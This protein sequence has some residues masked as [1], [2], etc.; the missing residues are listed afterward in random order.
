MF[1]AVEGCE[2][3]GKSCFVKALGNKLREEKQKVLL[4]REPG[5]SK[6][7]DSL[8]SL[9][10]DSHLKISPYAELF[11]FLAGRAHHIYDT[12]IPALQ[13]GFIVVSDRFHDSTI[14]YQGIAE[15]L[16]ADYVS[17][18]CNNVSGN[19]PFYPDLTILLDIPVEEGLARKRH[20]KVL[21][22]FEEKPIEY[23]QK[24]R[25]GF[26]SLANKQPNRYCILDARQSIEYSIN[27]LFSKKLTSFLCEK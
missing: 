2:G 13:E 6:L 10:L 9:L 23:H 19:Q 24:I 21:D 1:I 27:Q 26:L 22:K 20:Q 4:T 25:E 16:G 11:L 3:A 7:G 15:N 17:Q 12:I 18:L 14:V 5:G 8:R